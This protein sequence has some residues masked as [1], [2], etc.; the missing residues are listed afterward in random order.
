MG[1][2]VGRDFTDDSLTTT[3]PTGNGEDMRRQKE[4]PSNSGYMQAFRS[5]T[6]LLIVAL[7]LATVLLSQKSLC[8]Q[9]VPTPT[10][11]PP[12]TP[13]PVPTPTPFPTPTPL[14][15]PTPT[16][17]PPAPAPTA[18]AT[19]TTTPT[20]PAGTT[21]AEQ[22][23]PTP[24]PATATPTPKPSPVPTRQ[25]TSTPTR[26][27]LAL[28]VTPEQPYV[29][30]FP[31]ETILVSAAVTNLGPAENNIPLRFLVPEDVADWAILSP[32]IPLDRAQS[33]WIV[34]EWPIGKTIT[35]RL[36]AT[37]RSDVPPGLVSDIILFWPGQNGDEHAVL[38]TL[39]Y[40]PDHL[41][42]V[43]GRGP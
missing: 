41:P 5:V 17:V 14:P 43:G 16:P 25:P 26:T 32:Q 1:A 20:V 37:A 15:L 11:I 19:A 7:L 22:P 21:Q 29:M 34:K 6:R 10:P 31:G 13:T 8:A 27:V 3:F 12:A 33:A 30:L 4:T 18:T 23:T 36:R 39:A 9:T 40:P 35:L 24:L 2:S 42:A 28:S 38:A